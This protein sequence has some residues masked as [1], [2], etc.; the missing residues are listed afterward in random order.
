MPT[1]WSDRLCLENRTTAWTPT[2]WGNWRRPPQAS[3]SQAQRIDVW[4][5]TDGGAPKHVFIDL[6]DLRRPRRFDL[7]MTPLPPH[8]IARSEGWGE[9][10]ACFVVK[11]GPPHVAKASSLYEN[12]QHLVGRMYRHWLTAP[13]GASPKATISLKADKD[14]REDRFEWAFKAND[15]C[16]FFPAPQ[17]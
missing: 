3:I 15:L 8:L 13:A 4:S 17:G 12:A 14:G 16:I 9:W 10:D 6:S 7:R 2:A 11:A 1:S 5:W